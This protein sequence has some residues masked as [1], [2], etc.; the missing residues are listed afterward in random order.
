M[1][2]IGVAAREKKERLGV[3]RAG[4][5]IKRLA[6]PADTSDPIHA[7]M[8]LVIEPGMGLPDDYEYTS[9]VLHVQKG[10]IRVSV[11]GGDASVSV[12]TGRPI[13]VSP[14]GQVYCATGSRDLDAGQE[15]VLGPGN[16]LSL[17]GG[18]A[19]VTT[20]GKVPAEVQ[21]SVLLRDND[22]VMHACWICPGVTD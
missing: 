21:M 2:A 16:G 15:V 7:L 17:V 20:L 11:T 22:I 10:R 6:Q 1:T 9:I 19:Q 18:I 5:D 4:G 14:R 13:R 8:N 3:Q 12:G